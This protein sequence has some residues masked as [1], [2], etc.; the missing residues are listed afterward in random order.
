[1]PGWLSAAT[2]RSAASW[3]SWRQRVTERRL[4][5]KLRATRE[6]LRVLAGREATLLLRLQLEGLEREARLLRLQEL[7]AD[8]STQVPQPRPPEP[9]S[10][11]RV[12]IDPV[13][14]EPRPPLVLPVMHRPEPMP[15]E[16]M[17]P[18]DEQLRALLLE[19]TRLSPASSES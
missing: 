1:M 9:L 15:E 14:G 19:N 4:E 2:S 3:T 6:Q 13:S 8:L 18:A 12:A 5:R 16:P 10:P 11:E 7:L 17:P